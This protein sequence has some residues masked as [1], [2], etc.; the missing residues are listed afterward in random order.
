MFAKHSQV[1]IY[2]YLNKYVLVRHAIVLS[3]GHIRAGG[4]ESLGM[5]LN[6]QYLAFIE[7]K[8]FSSN[9]L[10]FLSASP[11]LQT[12]RRHCTL[13]CAP[14]RCLTFVVSTP[15]LCSYIMTARIC[16]LTIIFSDKADKRNPQMLFLTTVFAGADNYSKPSVSMFRWLFLFY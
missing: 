6:P 16:W 3:S 10:N 1:F 13:Y 15:K 14:N 9:E 4:T 5:Q 11:I 12:F 2:L 8:H 7:V